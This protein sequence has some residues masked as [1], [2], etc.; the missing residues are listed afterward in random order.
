MKKIILSFSVLFLSLSFHA[1][2]QNAK[3]KKQ[4][5]IAPSTSEP[6]G[7][8]NQDVIREVPPS[9][10]NFVHDITSVEV[11]P[12]YPDGEEALMHYIN[13][14]L[15]YPKE[16][17]ENNIQGKVFVQFVVEKDG[18]ISNVKLKSS[19]IPGNDLGCNAEAIRVVKTIPPF[20][21]GMQNGKPIRV[22]YT[23]PIVYKLA[24]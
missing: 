11:I 12:K 21:P 22:S 6:Q 17:K 8:K 18:K 2:G 7:V 19:K 5:K 24:N 15:N 4:E 1:T 23:L 9:E 10:D 14:H 20:K 16:A 13:T 3:A